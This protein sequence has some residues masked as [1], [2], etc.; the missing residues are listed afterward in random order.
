M[1][2]VYSRVAS[3][4]TA[5]RRGRGRSK[6]WS[7]QSGVRPRDARTHTRSRDRAAVFPRRRSVHDLARPLRPQPCPG[8]YAMRLSAQCRAW[9]VKPSAERELRG[10][11]DGGV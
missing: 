10:L 1:A 5:L 8:Q 2:H 9:D 7:G 11:R 3:T 6:V 4:L